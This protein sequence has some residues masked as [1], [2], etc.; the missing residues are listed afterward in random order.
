MSDMFLSGDDIITM[1]G[2][3]RSDAQRRVLTTM[4][5]E[6]RARPDGS[7]AVLRAHIEKLFGACTNTSAK[8]KTAPDFSQVL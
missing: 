3:K 8:R 6:F 7:L 1:T 5:V 2:R 4:G